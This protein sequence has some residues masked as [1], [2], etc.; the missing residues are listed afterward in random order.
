MGTACVLS[1]LFLPAVWKHTS[2]GLLL[3]P[4]PFKSVTIGLQ[5]VETVYLNWCLR[6][7][8]VLNVGQISSSFQKGQINQR[9]F[10][11]FT[12]YCQC[13]RRRGFSILVVFKHCS[14]YEKRIIFYHRNYNMLGLLKESHFIIFLLDIPKYLPGNSC[15]TEAA[16]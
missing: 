6:N 12:P 1:D 11:L 3:F 15:P 10:I 8:S 5:W 14:P 16:K 4:K 13:L 2:C 7:L 9:Y